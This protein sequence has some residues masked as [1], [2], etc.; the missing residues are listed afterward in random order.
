MRGREDTATQTKKGKRKHYRYT[1]A[2]GP[3]KGNYTEF[4]HRPHSAPTSSPE[5]RKH[6]KTQACRQ[7]FR[8]ALYTRAQGE[9]PNVHQQMRESREQ[10]LP[11]LQGPV[12]FSSV[13]QSCLTPCNPMN[14]ST[15]G[16]PV[17][18]TNSQSS[19]KL[20]C[21]ESVM[22]PSHFILCRPLLLLPP[23]PPSIRVICN[24]STLPGR[25]IGGSS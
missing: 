7:V 8:A 15:P 11:R 10:C 23:I 25:N 2:A 24:E 14:P 6:R 16:L 22:L 21:I 17:S 4:S 20:M 18:I 12:Q 5:R 19:Y 3:Q 13:T 9:S 1:S